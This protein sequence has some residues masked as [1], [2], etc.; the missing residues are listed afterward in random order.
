MPSANQ[1]LAPLSTAQARLTERYFLIGVPNERS[2]EA[3]K[4][5]VVRKDYSLTEQEVAAFARNS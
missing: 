4:L 2:G 3:V 1:P 5:Y